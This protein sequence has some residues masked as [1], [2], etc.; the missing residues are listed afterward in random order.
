MRVL[1]FFSASLAL[2]SLMV[3][4]RHQNNRGKRDKGKQNIGLDFPNSSQQE[5]ELFF[6]G[7]VWALLFFEKGEFLNLVVGLSA[8]GVSR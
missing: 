7:G 3:N 5:E 8:R 2:G 1:T 4:G 6:G